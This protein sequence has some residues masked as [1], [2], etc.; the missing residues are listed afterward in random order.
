[1]LLLVGELTRSDKA[2]TLLLMRLA[3]VVVV[4][5]ADGHAHTARHRACAPRRALADTPLRIRIR[6]THARAHRN[7]TAACAV[8]HYD[9]SRHAAHLPAVGTEPAAG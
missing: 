6:Y 8:L 9:E 5:D 2:E 7:V 3:L 4:G 1:M